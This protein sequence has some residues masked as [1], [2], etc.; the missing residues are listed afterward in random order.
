MAEEDWAHFIG[1]AL[2]ALAFYMIFV[3]NAILETWVFLIFVL[4]LVKTLDNNVGR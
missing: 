3:Y 2:F 4:I 1:L